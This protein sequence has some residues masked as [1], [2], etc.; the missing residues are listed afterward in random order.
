MPVAPLLARFPAGLPLSRRL[1]AIFAAQVK[2]LP[3]RT[4]HMLL[5]M[6]LDGTGGPRVL[7]LTAPVRTISPRRN[8]RGWPMSITGPGC[9]RSA[10]R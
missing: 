8:G 10:T 7:A 3:E 9:W 2:V 5:L 1:E 6:A 4:R